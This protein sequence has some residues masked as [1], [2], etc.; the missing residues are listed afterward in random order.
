MDKEQLQKLILANQH[1][2][3][4]TMLS[5]DI[6]SDATK[7]HR[8]RAQ[9]KSSSSTAKS[10]TIIHEHGSAAVLKPIVEESPGKCLH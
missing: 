4:R 5:K 3:E 6:W 2:K 8:A 1:I 7:E 10:E 9:V